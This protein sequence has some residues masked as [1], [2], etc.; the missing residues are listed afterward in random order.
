MGYP[1]VQIG[2]LDV[3]LQQMLIEARRY[4]SGHFRRQ[5]ALTRMI[6]LIAQSKKLW[7][8]NTP[9]MPMLSSKHGFTF[10]RISAK[11]QQQSAMTQR[12]GALLHDSIATSAGDCKTCVSKSA[13]SSGGQFLP[14]VRGNILGT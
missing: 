3:Q 6:R 12:V 10:V 7:Q 8:E 9:Y 14:G 13:S 5:Q 11:P 1:Q 4:P 2:S